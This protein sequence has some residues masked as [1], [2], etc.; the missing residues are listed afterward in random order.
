VLVY[1]SL[2]DFA[3]QAPTSACDGHEL[4]GGNI[5]IHGGVKD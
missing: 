5:Q 2:M 4:D 1:D 3:D